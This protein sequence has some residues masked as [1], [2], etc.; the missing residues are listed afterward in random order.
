M[1]VE[2][3]NYRIISLLVRAN[4]IAEEVI[5]VDT[6]S[7]DRTMELA[8]EFGCKILNYPDNEIT[9]PRLSSFFVN[10]SL[11]IIFLIL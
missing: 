8:S 2:I 10:Q 1:S 11:M 6:G 7:N 5:F 9:A 4:E 3:W